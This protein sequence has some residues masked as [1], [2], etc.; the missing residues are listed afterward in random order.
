MLARLHYCGHG[1]TGGVK[2]ICALGGAHIK[3]RVCVHM[4]LCVCLLV[5]A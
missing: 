1:L 5:V 3:V 2:G 4:T